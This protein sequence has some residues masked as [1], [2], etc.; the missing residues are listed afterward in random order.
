MHGFQHRLERRLRRR[1]DFDHDRYFAWLEAS[2][3]GSTQPTD[4]ESSVDPTLPYTTEDNYKTRI[5]VR[6]V[7]RPSREITERFTVESR[8]TG[9]D[10]SEAET[11]EAHSVDVDGLQRSIV[12]QGMLDAEHGPDEVMRDFEV[13][14]ELGTGDRIHTH[15]T[16]TSV[17]EDEVVDRIRAYADVVR[18]DLTEM[19]TD[20]TAVDHVVSEEATETMRSEPEDVSL[21]SA[22]VGKDVVDATGETVGTV[23]DVTDGGRTAH[24]DPHSSVTE[25]VMSTLNW[26]D[27]D[28]GETEIYAGQLA[29]V[30]DEAI[31]LKEHEQLAEHREAREHD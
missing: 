28:G 12:E 16:R 3:D 27:E 17:V 26:G 15:F 10:L 9:T 1:R 8:I 2:R 5:D 25:D 4:G 24:V 14:S 30:T 31:Q 29:A 21:T 6:E 11:L 23:E 13:E 19:E 18:A 22:D 20:F 7:W